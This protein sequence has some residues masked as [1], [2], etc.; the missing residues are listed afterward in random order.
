[1]ARQDGKIRR[2]RNVR[3]WQR[4]LRLEEWD[5][6]CQRVSSW[7]VTNAMRQRTRPN[8]M[9]GVIPE[10]ER[11]FAT[12]VHTRRLREDDIVHELYHVKYPR[13]PEAGVRLLTWW[14][15]RGGRR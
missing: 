8:E 2:S 13:L 3:E 12:I 10:R 14:C 15:L 4:R 9:V 11:R 6:V 7:Q 1:M 5:V